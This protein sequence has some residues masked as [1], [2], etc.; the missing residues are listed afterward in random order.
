MLLLTNVLGLDFF[1]DLF[2]LAVS[3][4]LALRRV[5]YIYDLV[6]DAVPLSH[7]WSSE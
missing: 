1:S 3:N 2:L 6:T 7:T 5:V 4:L